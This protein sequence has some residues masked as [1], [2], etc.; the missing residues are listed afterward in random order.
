LELVL[1]LDILVVVVLH[2]G[3]DRQLVALDAGI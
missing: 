2:P 1:E 3:I